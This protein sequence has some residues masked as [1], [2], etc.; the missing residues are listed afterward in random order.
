VYRSVKLR[1]GLPAGGGDGGHA[2]VGGQNGFA[3]EADA[4]TEATGVGIADDD[5]G[6][7]GLDSRLWGQPT[8]RAEAAKIG[9]SRESIAAVQVP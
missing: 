4:E 2:D 5:A 1:T 8:S 6:G 3:T 9:M 7:V